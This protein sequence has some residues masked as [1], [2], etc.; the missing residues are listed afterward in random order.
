[1]ERVLCHHGTFCSGYS[2][3]GVTCSLY[4][5]NANDRGTLQRQDR[6][7]AGEQQLWP[8]FLRVCEDEVS[9]AVRV[10]SGGKVRGLEYRM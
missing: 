3:R 2:C 8:K 9:G 7:Q 5:F 1:M 6:H 4:P 10:Q